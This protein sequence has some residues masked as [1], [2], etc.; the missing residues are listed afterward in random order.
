MTLAN[1]VM[2]ALAAILG[3]TFGVALYYKTG[4]NIYQTIIQLI[5]WAQTLDVVNEEKMTEV[6][7][8]LYDNLPALVKKIASKNAIR[9]IAQQVYDQMKVWYNEKREQEE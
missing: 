3:A 2:I 9:A 7:D 4:K 8:K 1:G 6:V 5:G